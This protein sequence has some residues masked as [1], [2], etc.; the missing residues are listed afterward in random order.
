[1]K[2]M[3]IILPQLPYPLTDGGNQAFYNEICALKDDFDITIL[4]L[5]Y[6]NNGNVDKLEAKLGNVSFLAFQYT[7]KKDLHTYYSRFARKISRLLKLD[8][9]YPD[10]Y[11]ESIFNSFQPE[12]V[13]YVE[14]VKEYVL[15]N[16]IDIVQF[17]M[18]PCLSK[19]LLLPREVKKIFVHHEIRFVV[20]EQRLRTKGFSVYRNT[21]VELAKIMEI[22]LLNKCD[23]VITLSDIDRDKLVEAGVNVPVYS[24]FAVVNTEVECKNN[25][26]GGTTLSFVGP[27][28]HSPNYVGLTWFLENCWEKLLRQ[29]AAYR[30]KII[31]NW[32]RDYRDEIIRKYK[33][34][35]FA[36]F[37]QNLAEALNGTIMIV[38]ITVGS[39]IRMKILEAA[40]LGIPFVS[41]SIGAEGLPFENGRDCLKGDTPEEFV[42]SILKMRDRSQRVECA[43]NAIVLVKEK[44]SM[45]ALR[46]NRLEIYEKIM[47]GG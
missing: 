44:F 18:I 24:S 41:T 45:E 7:K 32:S 42:D 28:S 38:P 13:E 4:Y 25:F 11:F 20:N 27:S 14:F 37:V 12:D 15:K 39:G 3:L 31:G 17:E 34:V 10:F 5:D 1:M 29:D 30:L 26:D 47:N 16:Q 46:R 33:N 40:S 43:K 6:N 21:Y 8:S 9:K 19:V 23:A 36:G 2:K 35:E 22:G